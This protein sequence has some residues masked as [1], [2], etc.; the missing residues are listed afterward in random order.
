L[1]FESKTHEAQLED[2][3]PRKSSKSH[4]EE[5]KIIR[6]TNGTKSGKSNKMANKRQEKLKAPP[7]ITPLNTLNASSLA[8][9]DIIMF[10][11]STTWL[12][13]SSTN[14]VHNLS[15]FDNELIKHNPREA[16][17]AIREIKIR[18]LHKVYK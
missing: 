12:A 6:P 17:D 13:K 9:I 15:P 3:K 16:Q 10:L 5:G 14:F 7:E 8:Q 2:Q 1:N 4:L 11:L 18:M